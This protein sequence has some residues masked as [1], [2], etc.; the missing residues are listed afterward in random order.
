MV[1]GISLLFPDAQYL[2]IYDRTWDDYRPNHMVGIDFFKTGFNARDQVYA[3]FQRYF[4]DIPND[5]SHLIRERQRL[6]LEAGISELDAAKMQS[7]LSDAAYPNTIPT[8]FWTVY[9]IYSRPELLQ[10]IRQELSTNAVDK[11]AGQF[12]LDVAAL[13]TNCHILL[14][15]YQE[16]QRMRHYQVA[17]RA[18]TQDT[19][20][21]GRHL[22]RKGNYLQMPAKPTHQ[23]PNIWGQD[24]GTFNPYRFVPLGSESNKNKHKIMPSNFL[25]W[26][27]APHMCPG[28]QFASTEIIII[29]A[30]LILRTDLTPKSAKGWERNPALLP[31]EI[32]SLP[33]PKKDV[34]LI[35]GPRKEALG[36]WS[37]I[38]G[39]ST[40][41]I[42]LASG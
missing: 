22:L 4:Q 37:I 42:S 10:A 13:K 29:A 26:G 24:A 31:M 2:E 19:L 18:I 1:S 3:S 35:L 16:T 32:P 11:S 7:T 33:R 9:E 25:P 34:C 6:M 38:L 28:R 5:A 12:K 30:L 17:F 21:D 41:R 40:T 39:K 15:A 8:L 20:L 27:A 36:Q 14:S 23:D